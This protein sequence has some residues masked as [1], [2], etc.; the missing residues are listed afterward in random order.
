[1]FKLQHPEETMG[2]FGA[3]LLGSGAY[4][5]LAVP[6]YPLFQIFGLN[7]IPYFIGAI[8]LYFIA[9]LIFWRA[10]VYISQNGTI[11]F[12]AA[13]IF[14]SGFMGSATFYRIINSYQT[15]FGFIFTTL[16]LWV[17]AKYLYKRKWYFYLTALALFVWTIE[18][19]FIRSHG[20][21]FGVL[22]LDLFYTLARTKE[23]RV[24]SSTSEVESKKPRR[25]SLTRAVKPACAG[26]LTAAFA[27]RQ[28]PFWFFYYKWYLTGNFG[29]ESVY[30]FIKEMIVNRQFEYLVPF[31]GLIGNV[32]VPD[33]LLNNL[34]AALQIDIIRLHW[35][36]FYGFI[37]SLFY[38]CRRFKIKFY[39]FLT[40]AL[41]A[42]G[43]LKFNLHY[44][45]ADI[46][47]HRN[48]WYSLMATVGGLM[49]IAGL[50]VSLANIKKK[51]IPAILLLFSIVWIP[52]NFL[53]YFVKYQTFI[54]D[55]THRYLHNCVFGYT[56]F[57][58]A[59]LYLIIP[60]MRFK[61]MRR[62]L[63]YLK[64]SLVVTM[65][66]VGANLYFSQKTQSALVQERSIPTRNFYQTL[67]SEVPEISPGAIFLFEIKNEQ[68]YIQQFRDFFSVGSMPETTALAIYYGMAR[69]E[70][71]LPESFD[72]LL[73]LLKQGGSI[74]QVYTFY[75]GP[76]GLINTTEQIRQT[77]KQ[78]IQSDLPLTEW[79]SSVNSQNSPNSLT[80][81]TFFDSSDGVTIGEPPVIQ[82]NSPLQA[83]GS[84]FFLEFDAKITPLK[85]GFPYQSQEAEKHPQFNGI[86]SL[87]LDKGSAT[88][89]LIF[90]YL[91]ARRE[92]YETAK[93]QTASEWK[94]QETKYLLDQKGN[95]SWRGHRIY[96]HDNNKD[97][98]L[99]DLG[100]SK[101]IGRLIWVN[102]NN[103]STIT[104]YIIS[105]S[106]DGN[107]WT[108]VK[109]VAGSPE[110][111][112]GEMIIDDFEPQP[113]HFVKMEILGTLDDDSPWISEIEV[114]EE[115]FKQVDTPE[116][117]FLRDEPFAY[118]NDEN[119]FDISLSYIRQ[120]AR[121]RLEWLT[122]VD[123]SWTQERSQI[124]P[125]FPDGKFHHYK[126]FA[127][128]GGTG[129]TQLKLDKL[130]FPAR[131]EIKN[132][133]LIYPTFEELKTQNLIPEFSEN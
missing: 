124:F 83:P 28:L 81:A 103:R 46:Y 25:F 69:D 42:F 113:A 118:I 44:L 41:A 17:W 101:N 40:A 119:D 75:F 117:Y 130:S 100:S 12:I 57:W 97:E 108:E 59:F 55:T 125:I 120:D 3:G 19:V 87:A 43:V 51:P 30:E 68:K 56:F 38:C 112:G 14:A 110:R 91:L 23:A 52:A 85:P 13:L 114:V 82:S 128:G 32:L 84:A 22:A 29:Q 80:T 16:T 89:K 64:G 92:Y 109:N 18:T 116:A 34:Q 115:K 49:V 129:L 122:N 31:F 24:N 88:R 48:P 71:K 58:A 27:L 67:L 20:V 36:L 102:G 39:W 47:W 99:I 127:A 66:L 4:R 107:N 45:A 90:D 133:K 106:T 5:Y 123:V 96:W 54:W 62:G 53:A 73:F 94:Y 37:V 111:N 60:D 61:F 33:V 76:E 65:L 79:E 131:L 63:D 98:I 132:V 10:A 35:Y 105:V 86:K 11:G 93:A 26:R 121:M 8:I 104:D 126:I 1:M 9:T 95:T 74:D 70:I 50:T 2:S 77:L 72:E 15:T 6:F 7:P 78:G 21:I